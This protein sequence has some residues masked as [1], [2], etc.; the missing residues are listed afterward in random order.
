M[1]RIV[2]RG[3][4]PSLVTAMHRITTAIVTVWTTMA[5]R[6]ALFSV[7]DPHMALTTPPETCPPNPRCGLVPPLPISRPLTPIS[8]RLPIAFALPVSH[9]DLRNPALET[10]DNAKIRMLGRRAAIGFS[11]SSMGSNQP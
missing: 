10:T 3:G 1:T 8:V 5:S 6:M 11:E 7:T 9:P 2:H 4:P